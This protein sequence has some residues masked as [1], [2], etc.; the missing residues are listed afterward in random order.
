MALAVSKRQPGTLSCGQRAVEGHFDTNPP[1]HLAPFAV[2]AVNVPHDRQ[3]KQEK[4][5]TDH[6]KRDLRIMTKLS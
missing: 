5:V 3:S 6:V 2:Q 1:Y 4:S